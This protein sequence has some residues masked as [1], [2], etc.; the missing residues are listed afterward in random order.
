MSVHETLQQI[1]VTIRG[2]PPGLIHQGKGRM[3]ADLADPNNG[4][5]TG[6]RTKEAEAELLAHWTIVGKKRVPAIPWV[7]I[8]NSLSIAGKDFKVKGSRKSMEHRIAATVSCGLDMI[9]IQGPPYEVYVDW[10]RI[11]PKT[12]SMVLLGRPRYREWS[13][14]FTMDV[15]SEMYA[16]IMILKQILVHAGKVVGA[17]AW[18]P[19]L[20]GPYGR[21]TVERFELK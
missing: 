16:D 1:L 10:V 6:G 13:A 9:P 21:F 5:K 7:Q 18:R 12:G 11:P 3:A 15:D 2:R 19:E 8:Y 4:K 17:G 20:K 14:T